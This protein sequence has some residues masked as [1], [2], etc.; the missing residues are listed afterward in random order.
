M[1][2]LMNSRLINTFRLNHKMMMICYFIYQKIKKNNK[3]YAD[4]CLKIKNF[5]NFN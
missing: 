4:Y 1:I 5:K 3:K 2:I